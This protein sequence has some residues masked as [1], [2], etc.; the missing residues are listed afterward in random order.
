L[1]ALGALGAIL[2][3]KNKE[4]LIRAAYTYN[5]SNYNIGFKQ[6]WIMTNHYFSLGVGYKL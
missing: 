2:P 3:F 5:F 6:D 4:I 1:G